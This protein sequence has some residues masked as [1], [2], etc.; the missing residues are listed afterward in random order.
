MVSRLIVGINYSAD[1]SQLRRLEE[2]EKMNKHEYRIFEKNVSDFFEETKI[3]GF[4]FDSENEERYFSHRSCDCCGCN[5]GGDRYDVIGWIAG[6]GKEDHYD[7]SVC[8]DCVYYSEHG[9][10]DDQTMMDIEDS[11]NLILINRNEYQVKQITGKAYNDK[12]FL[13]AW[14]YLEENL[15]EDCELEWYSDYNKFLYFS[16][17]KVIGNDLFFCLSE[18]D[19]K[20]QEIIKKAAKIY[21]G[22]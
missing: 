13:D 3:N 17:Y 8:Q 2:R 14:D 15:S 22:E 4:S 19:E 12:L 9:V 16:R 6:K 18:L 10:L 1:T 5:L 21:S 7:L 11:K 20:T